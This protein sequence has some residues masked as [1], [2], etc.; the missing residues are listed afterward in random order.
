MVLKIGGV[1]EEISE[2]TLNPGMSQTGLFTVI[3]DEPGDYYVEID[4]QR[5]IFTVNK[6]LPPAFNISNLVITPDKVKQGDPV[7]ISIVVANIGEAKGR[8]NAELTVKGVVES[9]EEIELEPGS[10]EI[11]TFTIVKDAAGFY[12]V[13]VEHL[14]GRFVVEMDWK[15]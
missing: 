6:R 15:G 5:G 11:V 10:S 13:A 3:K 7:S 4:G 8:Y 2:F 1:V 14:S 12:P 9:V